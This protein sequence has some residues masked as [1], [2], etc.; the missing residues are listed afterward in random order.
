M[1]SKRTAEI[2]KI[3]GE[4]S[5][6][7]LSLDVF[8]TLLW[9]QVSH[10]THVFH[11]TALRVKRNHLHSFALDPV[12]FMQERIKAEEHARLKMSKHNHEV[13]IAEIYNCLDV[14]S[15]VSND[16][17]I[18]AE[19]ASEVEVLKPNL[20][21]FNVIQ[22][23][24][25]K[26]V[27]VVL[28]SDMY[29]P[30]SQLRSM[31]DQVYA[32]NGLP[33]FTY[34]LFVSCDYRHGKHSGGLYEELLKTLKETKREE[35]LHIGDNFHA[36]VDQADKKG[37][38]SYYF[39]R[40][41]S[42][43][44]KLLA[45]EKQYTS[46]TPLESNFGLD[47]LRLQSVFES[48]ALLQDND[49]F[50]HQS[51]G[52]FILGPVFTL[53][54]EW[55]INAA[56]SRNQKVVYCLM[57]DGY[58][59][60]RLIN[61]ICE[62]RGLDIKAKEIWISRRIIKRASIFKA[63][64][65]ELGG[66]FENI[67]HPKLSSLTKDLG[68]DLNVLRHLTQITHDEPLAQHEADLVL[69][70]LEQ[71]NILKKEIVAH[72][73]TVRQNL[74][75]YLS[76]EGFFDTKNNIIVDL[77]WGGTIQKRLQTI[78]DFENLAVDSLGLYLATHVGIKALNHINVEHQGFLTNQGEEA[79]ACETIVCMPEIL[80]QSCMDRRGTLC[81][82]KED[83]VIVN[84]EN[85]IPVE[86]LKEL[87]ELQK[88]IFHFCDLWVQNHKSLK[89]TPQNRTILK[90]YLLGVLVPSIKAPLKEEVMLFSNWGHDTNDGTDEVEPIIGTAEMRKRALSMSRPEILQL[91]RLDC[92]WPEGLLAFLDA[93][94]GHHDYHRANEQVYFAPE[95]PVVALE[96][97]N[98]PPVQESLVA[99]PVVFESP[100]FT[101]AAHNN[102][103]SLLN[104]YYSN[105]EV[106][107]NWY[108]KGGHLLKIMTGRRKLFRSEK[109]QLNRVK[110][111][112]IINGS[113]S[114][115]DELRLWYYLE[116][117]SLPKW[118]K[119][120]G[121]KISNN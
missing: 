40:T 4:G 92:Y 34:D 72:S 29:W 85:L 106:L 77:G 62:A 42:L 49:Q 53:F 102:I 99:A 90:N 63:D 41:A 118:Y 98:M 110:E 108:K 27:K 15:N 30:E 37:L 104:Y 107:P 76:Q 44:D 116:Y 32:A 65:K 28:C 101:P 11:Q 70:K 50:N 59:I 74:L 96:P 25:Q 51:Y 55:I 80:E 47:S 94:F 31:I 61:K 109:K 10:P 12:F 97:V 16:L 35:I 78:F 115:Y 17:L 13:T 69:G 121:V 82:I 119:K 66:F 2:I 103:D 73:K 114:K 120:F 105:Y 1:K 83:G 60:S 56:Q 91:S 84:E 67:T 54:A 52:S 89:F 33:A 14:H 68:I 81:E 39:K 79:Y 23:C 18:E 112:A 43:Y 24:A 8:D 20:T 22:Y 46:T 7:V 88:G 86:Q 6:K 38:N 45:R 95:P 87:E 113:Y 9:R 117:E 5:I 111:L 71:S 21:I 3:L 100:Q 93:Q 36:D 75:N 64:K 58:L 19:L 26:K 57:R 48:E